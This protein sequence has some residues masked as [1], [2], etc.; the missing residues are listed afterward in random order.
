MLLIATVLALFSVSNARADECKVPP[1]QKHSAEFE[2]MKTL[3]GNWKGTT[4]ENGKASEVSV[5]YHVSSGGNA[6]I[7]TLFPGTPHEMVSVYHDENGK[8]S[9]THYCMIGNRPKL[10]LTSATARELNFDFANDNTIDPAKEDHMHSLNIAFV[11]KN[12]IIQNWSGYQK[13]EP[14]DPTAFSLTRVK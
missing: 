11:D 12:R 9:M 7:E 5:T 6:V 8:L 4:T 1:P 10:S 2:R 13:G 3:E 14:K